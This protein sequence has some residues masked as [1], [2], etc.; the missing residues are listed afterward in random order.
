MNKIFIVII[1]GFL[2]SF[3]KIESPAFIGTYGTS[4]SDPAQISLTIYADHT[5]TYTD[6][7]SRLN[8]INS[9]GTWSEK[10]QKILLTDSNGKKNFHRIWTFHNEG[11]QAKSH[12]GMTF[13]TLCR[14]NN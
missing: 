7:S 13:Y 5:Y 4:V 3:V 1:L 10:G 11:K 8:K 12:K 2:T 9:T 6:Y 14:N